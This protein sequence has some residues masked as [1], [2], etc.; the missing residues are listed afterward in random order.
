[1]RTF[2]SLYLLGWWS[3]ALG[4]LVV[5]RNRVPAEDHV[6]DGVSRDTG[7]VGVPQRDG[8][9]VLEQDFLGFL[10]LRGCVFDA[11]RLCAFLE[12]VV[13]LFARVVLVVRS[14]TGLV[15]RSEEVVHRRVVRLPSC[16]GS[17][18]Q[19]VSV[20]VLESSSEGR[21]RLANG[22]DTER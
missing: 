6:V 17:T 18:G 10:V 9:E 16:T 8:R 19:L 3:L 12:E 14:G 22:F 4:D 1:P 15:Q 5:Q 21:V 2:H 7:H 13:E 11:G 20:A